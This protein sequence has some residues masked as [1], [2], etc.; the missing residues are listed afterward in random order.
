MVPT[1]NSVN[2]VLRGLE[3]HN[4]LKKNSFIIKSDENCQEYVTLSHNTKQKNWQGGIDTN[5]SQKE[6]RM[7]AIP[8][9]GEKS[10]VKSLKLFLSKPKPNATQLF[11]HCSKPALASPEEESVWFSDVPVN[12]LSVHSFHV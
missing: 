5:D 3:V 2:F 6:K 8:E 9:L 1:V 11:N 7:Y 12:K 4:Q 10:P